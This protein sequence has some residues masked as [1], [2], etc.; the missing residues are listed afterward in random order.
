MSRPQ[1]CAA[2]SSRP[3]STPGFVPSPSSDRRQAAAIR[4]ALRS[5]DSTSIPATAAGARPNADST[6]NR[7]P[8]SGW[9]K[10]TPAPAARARSSRAEPGSV[11]ASAADEAA[12]PSRSSS[13]SNPSRVSIVPPDLEAAMTRNDAGSTPSSADAIS[14]GSVV[15]RTMYSAS[16]RRGNA[17]H[18]RSA[19]SAEPPMPSSRQRSKGGPARCSARSAAAISTRSPSGFETDTLPS[20]STSSQPSHSASPESVH[21]ELSRD[22][23]RAVPSISRHSRRRRSRAADSSGS[24]PESSM[25]VTGANSSGAEGKKRESKSC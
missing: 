20:R 21:S 2:A 10:T 12:G 4:R 7:P 15:S 13:N 1:S 5:S 14:R 19:P 6:E 11:I 24:A 25:A 9:P 23:R 3:S 22:Q 8:M 17:R 18:S 16:S